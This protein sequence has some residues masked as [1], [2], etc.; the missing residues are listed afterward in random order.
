MSGIGTHWDNGV[1]NN[2]PS[3]IRIGGGVMPD[4]TTMCQFYSPLS[5][6][7]EPGTFGLLAMG[8]IAAGI[9]GYRVDETAENWRR[10]AYGYAIGPRRSGRSACGRWRTGWESCYDSR[11]H[12][13]GPRSRCAA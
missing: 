3:I 4:G 9:A 5:H 7:P 8:M 13:N 1:T 6:V 11:C 12:D 10:T 2:E